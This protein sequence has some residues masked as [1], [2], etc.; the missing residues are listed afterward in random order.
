MIMKIVNLIDVT[1]VTSDDFDVP[2]KVGGYI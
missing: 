2:A 1:A